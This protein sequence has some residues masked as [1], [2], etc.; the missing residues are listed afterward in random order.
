MTSPVMETKSGE[1]SAS[2][3]CIM[4][5]GKIFLVPQHPEY[6]D[7]TSMTGEREVK[8]EANENTRWH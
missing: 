6:R 1:C 4:L 5:Q 2:L 8:K 3:V 7:K